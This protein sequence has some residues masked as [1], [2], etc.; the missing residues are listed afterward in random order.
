MKNKL[1]QRAL[2]S[3]YTCFLSSTALT[4]CQTYIK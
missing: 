2:L 3:K 4:V 1:Y